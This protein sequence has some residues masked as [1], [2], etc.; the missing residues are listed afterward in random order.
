MKIYLVSVPYEGCQ[1]ATFSTRELAEAYIAEEG[2][3]CEGAWVIE[4]TLDGG[5]T[6]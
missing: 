3:Y 4:T 2:S 1:P 6:Y 5:F